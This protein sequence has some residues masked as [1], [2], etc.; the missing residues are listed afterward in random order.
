M[1]GRNPIFIH[2]VYD[3]NRARNFYKT[4]FKVEAAFESPGWSTLN[5]GVFELALHILDPNHLDEKP[6]PHAG[7]NLQVDLIEDVQTVIEQNGGQLL[8][9]REPEVHVPDRVASF[10]DPDGNG[11]ELRQ[12]VG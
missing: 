7:L 11:F 9:L 5:F 12:H 10:Q 4:V 2:Y 6:L 8:V 3:M 1:V